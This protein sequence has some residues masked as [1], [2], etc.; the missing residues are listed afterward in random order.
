M[1]LVIPERRIVFGASAIYRPTILTPSQIDDFITRGA[2]HLPHAIE[3]DF[4]EHCAREMLGYMKIDEHRPDT[5]RALRAKPGNRGEPEPGTEENRYRYDTH[6]PRLW[7][8]MC[9]LLGDPD[10]IIP[11]KTFRSNGVYNLADPDLLASPFPVSHWL[12]PLP[13]ENR[14]GWHVD[15]QESWFR[16]YLDSPQ[17]AL[18]VLILFRDSTRLGGATWYAPQSPALMSRYYAAHPEGGLPQP[19]DIMLQCTEFGI[20][21]G[22]AGDAF[23]LHP[24]MM[25]SSAPNV[26]PHP[27]LMENDNI[28]IREPLRFDREN[29]ADFS[30]VERSILRH[31]KVDRLHFERK[32]SDLHAS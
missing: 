28:S 2:I 18:L 31:L 4:A 26:L 13:S 10:R 1:D 9:D 14:G 16:H 15:G 21:E 17:V 8:A 23:L 6:A 30:V 7:A 25:H 20:A 12:A 24:F 27:R 29:P 11:D 19:R 32:N 3:P 22:R 5:W